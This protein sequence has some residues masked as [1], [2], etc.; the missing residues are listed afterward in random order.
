MKA[1][2]SDV[3]WLEAVGIDKAESRLSRRGDIS[4]DQRQVGLLSVVPRGGGTRMASGEA[5]FTAKY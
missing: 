2:A 4:N 5:S 3:L 1:M